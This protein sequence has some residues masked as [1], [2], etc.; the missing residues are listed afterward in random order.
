M[1]Q[2]RF[3]QSSGFVTDALIGLPDGVMLPLALAAA[4]SV[5]APHSDVVLIACGIEAVL[6]AVLFGLAS[7]FTTV[8]QAEENTDIIPAGTKLEYTPFIPHLQLKD[9]IARLE[10]G[11]EAMEKADY[12]T[13]QYHKHWGQMLSEYGVGTPLLDFERARQSGFYVALTF[14]TGAILIL[15]PYFIADDPLIA[16]PYSAIIALVSLIILGISKSVYTGLNPMKETL[17][18]I[19]TCLITTLA[20]FGIAYLFS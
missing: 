19:L 2:S 7:Y 6:L 3:L 4:M 11:R 1:S 8:N 18:L 13:V 20:A 9:I 16:L 17:R 10:L 12:E 5:I 15:I 14:I